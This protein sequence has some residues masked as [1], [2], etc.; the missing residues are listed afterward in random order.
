MSSKTIPTPSNETIQHNNLIAKTQQLALQHFKLSN[1]TESIAIYTK[2]IKFCLSLTPTQIQN[3]RL[4]HKLTSRPPD[5]KPDDPIYHPKFSTLLDSRAAC[6]IK[7]GE[8]NKALKDAKNIVRCDPYSSKGHIRLGKVYELMKDGKLAYESYSKGLKYLDVGSKKFGIK[9]NAAAISQLQTATKRLRLVLKEKKEQFP[10]II[11]IPDVP[12]GSEIPASPTSTDPM[13]VFPFEL[14]DLILREL[15]FNQIIKQCLLVSHK[16]HDI[17]SSLSMF[18][19][20]RIKAHSTVNDVQNCVN[21]ITKWKK[22]HR[23][24]SNGIPL[25]SLK[26]G[27][28]SVGEERLIFRLL[29]H[30]SNLKILDT[31]DLQFNQIGI[32]DIMEGVNFSEN[33]E[34]FL[35]QVKTLKLQCLFNPRYEEMLLQY[36]PNIQSL[37]LV[38]SYDGT[39]GRL[40]LPKNYQSK[41]FVMKLKHLSILGDIKQ[42]YISVP[43]HNLFVRD[44]KQLINLES[45]QIVGYDFTQL[46]LVNETYNFLQRFPKLRHLVLENNRNLTLRHLLKNHDI[47]KL[48]RLRT[49]V[50]REREVKYVESLHLFELEYLV[51]IFHGLNNLDLTNSSISYHGL[52]TLLQS[53]GSGSLRQLSIGACQ[54]LHFPSSGLLPF[55]A[56]YVNI[57]ELLA[58]APNLVKLQLNQSSGF[59]DY[60]LQQFILAIKEYPPTQ[61]RP[62]QELLYLDLS[63]NE[64]LQSHTVLDFVSLLPKLK[65]LIIHGAYLNNETEVYLTRRFGIKVESLVEKKSW[66]VYGVNTYDPFNC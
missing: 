23:P 60:T 49:F 19:D 62:L 57:H 56:Q 21:K 17:C 51:N 47:L 44:A 46:N 45:L 61:V 2:G 14:I 9:N 3:I 36:L 52:R 50:F 31:L 12:N 41:N 27:I 58:L 42:P 18:D 5:L 10:Q 20:I 48:K 24:N 26:V 39:R 66:K 32:K 53:T 6:Y 38:P 59:T 7:T 16:W 35:K 4:S 15:P 55:N 13:D 65:H 63:F 28:T 43:F 54:H 25:K 8:L 34:R 33:A 22:L 40:T 1:F 11:P 30:K 64:G 37:M 29:L